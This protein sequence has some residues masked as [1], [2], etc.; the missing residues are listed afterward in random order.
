MTIPCHQ[1]QIQVK[2]HYT[3]S[4]KCERRA[5]DVQKTQMTKMQCDAQKYFVSL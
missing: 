1:F 5:K 2:A 4:L 3:H